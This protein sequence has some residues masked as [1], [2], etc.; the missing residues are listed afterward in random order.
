[1]EAMAPMF[2]LLQTKEVLWSSFRHRLQ[3][4]LHIVLVH[5]S[6]SSGTGSPVLCS[7]MQH[8]HIDHYEVWANRPNLTFA[9]GSHAPLS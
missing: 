7:A 9:V 4:N 1:M 3:E 5:H 6:G 2:D 8:C